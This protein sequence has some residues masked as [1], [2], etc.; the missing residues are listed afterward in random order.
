MVSY[1]ELV[2]NGQA[3]EET[4]LLATRSLFVIKTALYMANMSVKVELIKALT[5][6][7]LKKCL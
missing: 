3:D 4:M 7:T 1:V 2:L 5:F 6:E